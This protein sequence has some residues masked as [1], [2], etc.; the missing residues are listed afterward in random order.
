ME[1]A[2]TKAEAKYAADPGAYTKGGVPITFN[3]P[4]GEGYVGGSPTNM[5]VNAP[6]G[7]Y[8]WSNTVTVGI[9]RTTGKAYTAYPDIGKG[10]P[11]PD[12][13]KNGVKR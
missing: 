8:R 3:R 13:L 4:V 10:M 9:D 11:M 12:P 1:T 2:I 7:E 5:K 6:I